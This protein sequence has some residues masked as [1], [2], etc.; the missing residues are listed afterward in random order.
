MARENAEPQ[1]GLT[2]VSNDGGADDD[3]N[4]ENGGTGPTPSARPVVVNGA[5]NEVDDLRSE[6]DRL[7]AE[8]ARLRAV[9]GLEV[10]RDEPVTVG[11]LLDA[12]EAQAASI[13]GEVERAV[14]EYGETVLDVVADRVLQRQLDELGLD[15]E[16]GGETEKE[17]ARGKSA[18]K[19]TS[20]PG[21]R[22]SVRELDGPYTDG[23]HRLV[24]YDKETGE[25]YRLVKGNHRMAEPDVAD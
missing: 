4:A 2:R 14:E 7:R 21:P 8:N 24:F 18:Q 20:K 19:K 3:E 11:D 22:R 12:N 5:D 1:G 6:R 16:S 15:D 10:R 17:E 23:S 25:A 13:R 9:A